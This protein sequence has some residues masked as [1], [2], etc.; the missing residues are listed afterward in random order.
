MITD[1]KIKQTL[2]ET[3]GFDSF[4]EGQ[5]EIIKSI[6]SGRDT[7]AIMPTG[8]GKSLCYQ[9]PAKLMPGLTVVISPLISLMKDQFRS[10]QSN[11]FK[12]A[13]INSNC[14]E[15]EYRTVM[16]QL[17]NRQLEMIFVAPE[18]FNNIEFLN[19]VRNNN[20]GLFVIDEAHCITHWGHHFRP[21]YKS[22][23]EYRH[24]LGSPPTIALTATATP[25]VRD[26]I[27]DTLNMDDPNIFVRG[28]ERKN[29]SLNVIRNSGTLLGD[30]R[31]I[32]TA[33]EDLLKGGGI[34]VVYCN[35]V[36]NVSSMAKSLNDLGYRTE[37]Y[38]SRD[39]SFKKKNMI[40]EKFMNNELDILVATNAFGMGVDKGNV[41][42]VIHA[43]IPGSLEAYYQEAGRG[44]RDGNP[45]EC[46][47]IYNPSDIDMQQFF[48]DLAFPRFEVFDYLFEMIKQKYINFEERGMPSRSIH[49][50]DEENYYITSIDTKAIAKF[51]NS[52]L[53][54]SEHASMTNKIEVSNALQAMGAHEWLT[55]GCENQVDWLVMKKGVNVGNI[56]V[57]DVCPKMTYLIGRR[58]Y[59]QQLLAQMIE[60]AEMEKTKCRQGFILD[61]FT[62]SETGYE[63]GKCDSCKRSLA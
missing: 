39:M 18:R 15:Q 42:L 35:T 52:K 30:V 44:G 12:S 8:Q 4:R 57:G 7:I 17:N 51:I 9:L 40:Q 34:A 11:G 49:Q 25:L 63:C 16:E 27:Q 46:Y 32:L 14:S 45:A 60:F 53:D 10:T 23:G 41:R 2:K 19:A 31:R 3:F 1:E 50:E 21:E 38:Y 22:L 61:Y 33:K 36:K 47:M 13:A 24:F 29:L 26:E 55:T 58:E 20:V 56:F 43:N 59:S 54:M 6:L 5:E 37:G 28:F 62:K 48:I